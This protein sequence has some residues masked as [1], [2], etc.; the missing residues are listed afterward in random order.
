M[1]ASTLVVAN[2]SL[3]RRSSG[4]ASVTSRVPA[5]ASAAARA[6]PATSSSEL[7]LL[8]DVEGQ[9]LAS[10]MGPRGRAALKRWCEAWEAQM[11]SSSCAPAS[12]V[13]ALK[14]LG[15]GHGWSQARVWDDVVMPLRLM[16]RGISLAD[17]IKMLRAI[18]GGAWEVS[19]RCTHDEAGLERVLRADLAKAFEDGESICVLANYWRPSGGHWSPVAGFAEEKVLILDTNNRR[20]PPHW[21][22]LA[23][24]VAALTRHN[25]VT[26][27][28]RGYALLRLSGGQRGESRA[29]VSI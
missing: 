13:A 8:Q 3:E 16:T 27:R 10:A 29:A 26:G 18:G 21:M 22:P 24:F 25:E 9:R 1:G 28:P 19:E 15:I 12:A 6:R 23:S 2:D 4:A 17:G 14:F 11:D 7:V 5:S 20:Q